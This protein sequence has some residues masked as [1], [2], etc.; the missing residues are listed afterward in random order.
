[1]YS[2]Y[3][4][5]QYILKQKFDIFMKYCITKNVKLYNIY[6]GFIETEAI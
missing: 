4:T 3:S 5:V 2:M 6:G 1:M